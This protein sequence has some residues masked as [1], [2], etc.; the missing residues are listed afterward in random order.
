MAARARW[1]RAD[2]DGHPDRSVDEI[3]Q[4]AREHDLPY[5]DEQLHFPDLRIE[6]EELDGRFAR[7]TSRSSP[8]T[9]AAPTVLLPAGRVH[10]V[11]RVQCATGWPER[12]RPERGGAGF[13]EEMLG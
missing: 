10:G 7:R 4:W 9:I 8:S 6:Y 2:Y 12:W 5:F 11:S 3:E 1:W 13:A